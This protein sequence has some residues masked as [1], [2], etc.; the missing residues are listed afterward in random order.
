V[1]E[2]RA[3]THFDQEDDE[4]LNI[5]GESLLIATGMNRPVEAARDLRNGTEEVRVGRRLRSALHR[6]AEIR[7]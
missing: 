1:K 5:I 2:A 3:S 4:M 6:L 7:L